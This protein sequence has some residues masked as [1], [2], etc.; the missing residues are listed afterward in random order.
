MTKS[1]EEVKRALKC[2]NVC[3]DSGFRCTSCPYRGGNCPDLLTDALAY[4]QQLESEVPRWISVEE[5]LPPVGKAVLVYAHSVNNSWAC[6]MIDMW[7]GAWLENADREWHKVTQWM[8]LP[9]PP[10]EDA[11]G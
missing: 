6:V 3:N 11:H 2:A 1:P 5:R 4:I 8:P 10:K 9:E 7:D